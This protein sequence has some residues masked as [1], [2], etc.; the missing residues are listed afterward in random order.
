MNLYFSHHHGQWNES[1]VQQKT[2]EWKPSMSSRFHG[3]LSSPSCDN[4][5][6]AN[7]ELETGKKPNF[8]DEGEAP[9]A[10]ALSLPMERISTSE[11]L[12]PS[13]S[14]KF[15][16]LFLSPSCDSYQFANTELETGK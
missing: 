1:S 2:Q 13:M 3:L 8:G 9:S 12:K 4:Y 14:S 10:M 5:Q 16:G 15:H 6:F 11:E 7:T